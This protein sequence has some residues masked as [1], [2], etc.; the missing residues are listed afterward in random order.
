MS[1]MPRLIKFRYW[2]RFLKML[3]CSDNWIWEEWKGAID[4]VD[5]DRV[6][7]QYTGLKDKNGKEIYTGDVIEGNLFDYRL[8]IMGAV[9]YDEEH[10]AYALQNDAGLT[11]LFKIDQREV[12]GN[13][14]ENPDLIDRPKEGA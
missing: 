3:F 9:V 5:P 13:I 7:M 4:Q 6:L 8:P 2:D 1:E 11:L 12:I 14:Y 10:A